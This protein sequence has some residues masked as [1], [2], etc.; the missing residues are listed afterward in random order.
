VVA[1]LALI[2]TGVALTSLMT[3]TRQLALLWGVL[4]GVGSGHAAM[5]LGRRWCSAGS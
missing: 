5:V 4:A 3:A 1:S 2:A